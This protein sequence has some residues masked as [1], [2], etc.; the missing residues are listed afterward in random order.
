MNQSQ[1]VEIEEQSTSLPETVKQTSV[2]GKEIYLVGT[3][4]VSKQSIE[5]VRRAIQIIQPDTVSVELCES[6]YRNIIDREQWK[7]TNIVKVIREGK[8]MLLL[9]SLIMTSFQKRIGE[10][11]GVTPG[12]EMV[13]AINQAKEHGAKLVLSDR[14]IQVTLKRT[15]G[16]LGFVQKM[17]MLSQLLASLFVTDEIDE[18]MIEELKNE[19]QL[20]DVLELMANEFPLVKG[21]LIDERDTYLAQQIRTAE[22]EKIV[23]VVGAGHVPGIL[24][25]IKS[26]K[27][28]DPL[29]EIPTPTIWPQLLKWGIPIVI[30]GLFAYGFFSGGTEHSLQSVYI[31]VLINGLL[32]ALGATIALGHPLTILSAF[33]AAPL[34]SLNPMIAAGW[35]SGLVQAF[36]RKPTVKDLEELPEAITS[37]KG[38]WRNPVSRIL[39]VVAL[40]NLGSMLGTFISGSWI[41]ART[42]AQ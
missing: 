15:W 34:T 38:F 37:V 6:R 39:L 32:S 30:I 24:Q 19:N 22:G 42:I 3:A 23:A 2:N 1:S 40:S 4:H 25:E 11:L 14:D 16:K 13:E 17:K 12:A 10:Q 27:S 41:A 8:A 20:T 36:V 35:V 28:L 7:K 5:D 18:K 9:A 31:W 26:E 21:T 29:V 33:L